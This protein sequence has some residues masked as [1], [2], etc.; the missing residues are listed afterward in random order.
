VSSIGT[1]TRL[2]LPSALRLFAEN[3]DDDDDDDDDDE[4]EEEEEDEDDQEE[5]EEGEEKGGLMSVRFAV[6]HGCSS[7]SRED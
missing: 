4:E 3:N 6:G 7:T 2:W 5:G 1:S